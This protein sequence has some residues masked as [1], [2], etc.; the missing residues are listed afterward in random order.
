[1]MVEPL[2]EIIKSIISTQ[3]W[4]KSFSSNC[5][6]E[7]HNANLIPFSLSFLNVFKVRL[8]TNFSSCEYNVLS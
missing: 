5:S 4:S 1:M 3:S 2:P 6:L 7:V 8:G